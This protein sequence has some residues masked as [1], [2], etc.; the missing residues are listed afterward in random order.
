MSAADRPDPVDT[1]GAVGAPPIK[2][3]TMARH[4]DQPLDPAARAAE[5]QRSRDEDARALA[6]GEKTAAQLRDENEVFAKLAPM[7]RVDLTASRSLG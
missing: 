2:S 6:S 5:K 4:G 7:S 3:S 1:L